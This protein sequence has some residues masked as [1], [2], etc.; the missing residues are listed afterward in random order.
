MRG[1]RYL[2]R[3]LRDTREARDHVRRSKRLFEVSKLVG[4]KDDTLVILDGQYAKGEHEVE[5]EN[6]ARIVRTC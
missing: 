6:V 2:N 1:G 3:T 5:V 4:C